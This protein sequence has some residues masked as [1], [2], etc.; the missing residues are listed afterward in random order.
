MSGQRTWL[1]LEAGFLFELLL[2]FSKI[3]IKKRSELV[4]AARTSKSTPKCLIKKL[5]NSRDFCPFFVSVSGGGRF[6]S[7]PWIKL[8]SCLKKK[9]RIGESFL[10]RSAGHLSE[11][12]YAYTHESSS[13]KLQDL[14]YSDKN[15]VFWSTFRGSS[16]A[17]P[18]SFRVLPSFGPMDHRFQ[19]TC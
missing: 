18:S 7:A 10:P 19:L 4:S 14:T 11:A 6:F 3:K 9:K 1:N 5:P 16:A 13:F 12:L 8:R 2:A 15:Q 17:S